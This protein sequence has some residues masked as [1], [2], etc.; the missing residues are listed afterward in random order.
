MCLRCVNTCGGHRTTMVGSVPHFHM[1]PRHG[2]HF[3]TFTENTALST[4]C[5]L[6]DL[7]QLVPYVFQVKA[8]SANIIL[9]SKS[10]CKP[11]MKAFL[12]AFPF[13]S[14]VQ[15]IRISLYL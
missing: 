10:I 2:L 3:K 11:H 9:H 15:W 13:I 6:T 7:F 4:L 5:N 8:L 12:R 1:G 14:L